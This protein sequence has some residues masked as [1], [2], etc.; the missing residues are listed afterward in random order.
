MIRPKY[1]LANTCGAYALTAGR[2]VCK[3]HPECTGRLHSLH[4]KVGEDH[5]CKQGLHAVAC[6][7]RAV[8]SMPRRIFPGPKALGAKQ[9]RYG[10]R[11]GFC[12]QEPQGK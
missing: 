3:H 1:T 11:N 4:S 2:V 8:P 6:N 12:R 9:S 5:L 7:K 10:F